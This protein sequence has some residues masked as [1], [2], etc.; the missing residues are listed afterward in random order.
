V[1]NPLLYN[2]AITSFKL[3]RTN[4]SRNIIENSLKAAIGSDLLP[5]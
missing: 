3:L 2:V 4:L 5:R 1:T